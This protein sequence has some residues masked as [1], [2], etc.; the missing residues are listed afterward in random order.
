[1]ENFK[2]TFIKNQLSLLLGVCFLFIGLSAQAQTYTRTVAAATTLETIIT[3]TVTTPGDDN[4]DITVPIGFNFPYYG[5]N[6]NTIFIDPDGYARFTPNV[7][8]TGF[9]NQDLSANCGTNYT[10]TLA[11]SWND[12]TG[13]TTGADGTSL[14][15][16]PTANGFAITWVRR[17]RDL[18]AGSMPSPLVT[19][20]LVLQT[21]GV[22]RFI[23]NDVDVPSA[24]NTNGISSTVGINGNNTGECNQLSFNT[25]LAAGTGTV[26]YTPGNHIVNMIATP[27]STCSNNGTTYNQPVAVT[28]ASAPLV[29]T[30]FQVCYNSACVGNQATNSAIIAAPYVCQTFMSTGSA[31]QTVTLANV[32]CQSQSANLYGTLGVTGPSQPI[33]V[34]CIGMTTNFTQ[35]AGLA[36]ELVCPGDATYYLGSLECCAPAAYDL[37]TR[38]NCLVPF[39]ATTNS[40]QTA[41]STDLID[42]TTPVTGGGTATVTGNV[43]NLG[44]STPVGAGT[45]TAALALN[46]SGQI[47][48]NWSFN[49][50]EGSFWDPF[51]WQ[52]V[53]GNTVV[54]Q[55]G[56]A[57]LF[58][59]GTNAESGVINTAV[60]AGDVLILRQSNDGAPA[61]SATVVTF[62]S[63]QAAGLVEATPVVVTGPEPGECVAIG[64]NPV[65]INLIN[66]FSGEILETCNFT[67][68][69]IENQASGSLS[70]NGQINISLAD[71]CTATIEP[72]DVLEGSQY[73]C[74]DNYVVGVS[75]G[76]NGPWTEPAV[77]NQL[78]CGDWFYRVRDITTGNSCWGRVK[79]EDKLAPELA[80]GSC[81]GIL[82][83]VLETTDTSAV[84]SLV[85]VA[86]P[87]PQACGN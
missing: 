15:Y 63:I 56:T 81:G 52:L 67:L 20:Q 1:M 60:M 4:P 49:S 47:S 42:L 23:L 33:Y 8:V 55:G 59:T 17:S 79:I 29:G 32:P 76:Q 37:A 62:N 34:G 35:P 77:I 44:P 31:S 25:T 68:T 26:T 57:N 72:D 9:T 28:F 53:R 22:I 87:G 61:N 85:S 38:F 54:S 70:C 82:S 2:F 19:F 43:I 80:C 86:A 30:V 75:K 11:P 51:T 84:T 21:N 71:D 66:P 24:T 16:G 50:G 27:V 5:G 6:Y 46:S 45:A 58:T 78:G 12:W 69:A 10:N 48:L 3:P 14:T 13:S 83:G 7:G 36:C 39:S 40:L 18:L 64:D 41:I 74:A 65:Q 73:S